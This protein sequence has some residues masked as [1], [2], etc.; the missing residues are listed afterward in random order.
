[1][2]SWV[3]SDELPGIG[4]L[5]TPVSAR[6]PPGFTLCLHGRNAGLT[7]R[8]NPVRVH[9]GVNDLP[10]EL[11]AAP[12]APDPGSSLAPF[13]VAALLLLLVALIAAT[14]LATRR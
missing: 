5:V 12:A 11:H 2:G 6:G 13:A 9:V 1:M 8:G 14:I 4:R 7:G 3:I 10:G